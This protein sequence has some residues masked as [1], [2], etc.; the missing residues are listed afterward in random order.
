MIDI[1]KE[2]LQQDEELRKPQEGEY[3]DKEGILICGECGTRREMDILLPDY[4]GAHIP[5]RYS[6]QMQNA[7]TRRTK[8]QNG[9][10]TKKTQAGTAKVRGHRRCKVQGL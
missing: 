10:T 8:R 5:C 3:R 6:V 1:F 7:E 9:R 4:G 2:L